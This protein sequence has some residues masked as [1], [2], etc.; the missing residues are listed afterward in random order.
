MIT[1]TETARGALKNYLAEETA[2]DVGLRVYIT[3]G[4]CSGFSY[5]MVIEDQ[6]DPSDDIFEQDGVRVI[7]DRFSATMLDGAEID[8]VESLMGAGFSVNNPNAVATCGCG[9][10]FRTSANAG[11][12]QTCH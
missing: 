6:V 10:S 8:Y 2:P 9:H 4:G 5:G 12:A 3:P 11:V 1:L 7:V